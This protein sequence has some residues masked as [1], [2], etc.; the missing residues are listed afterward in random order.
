ML[1]PSGWVFFPF[2]AS[3]KLHN[4]SN[5]A[6][7]LVEYQD[8]SETSWTGKPVKPVWQEEGLGQALPQPALQPPGRA[9][10]CIS[11]VPIA[12]IC[13]PRRL[14]VTVGSVA[15]AAPVVAWFGLWV[16]KAISPDSHA[17]SP[18]HPR[19]LSCRRAVGTRCP[20]SGERLPCSRG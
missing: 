18:T 12:S 11:Q 8:H 1:R 19:R 15:L 6:A 10:W 20:S 5:A 9:L 3:L 7:S 4:V 17:V 13:P 2:T 14:P 16:S